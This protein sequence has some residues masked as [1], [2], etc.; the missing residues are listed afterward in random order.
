M[1]ISLVGA[2][3]SDKASEAGSKVSSLVDFCLEVQVPR[4]A[5]RK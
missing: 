2:E 5:L 4:W 1:E 3:G